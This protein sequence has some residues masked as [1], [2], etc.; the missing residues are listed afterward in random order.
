[1]LE[2]LPLIVSK[3]EFV[4]A[5]GSVIHWIGRARLGEQTQLLT[6]MAAPEGDGYTLR[7]FHIIDGG[8]RTARRRIE[9]L[10]DG[11]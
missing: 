3:P 10:R 11:S 1:M 7:A 6:A 8:V 2:G 9:R 4:F 5:K